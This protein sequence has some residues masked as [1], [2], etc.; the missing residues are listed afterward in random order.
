[1]NIELIKKYKTEFDHWL[2]GKNLLIRNNDDGIWMNMSE[3]HWDMDYKTVS[4]IIN[5]NFSELRK[6][7]CDGKIIQLYVRSKQHISDQSQDIYK[8]TDFKSLTP[9]SPFSGLLKNYRI[10]PEEPKFKVGDFVRVGCDGDSPK[11]IKIFNKESIDEPPYVYIMKDGT[12]WDKCIKCDPSYKEL[13]WFTTRAAMLDG[14]NYAVLGYFNTII[15]LDYTTTHGDTFRHC[16]PFLNS[17]P[18]WF[19]D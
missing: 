10:K 1:M 19:K 11:T 16:E 9:S 17:K 15:G 14:V 4:I 2:N 13:C 3:V 5:D 7:L 6:A 8:W 18:S 12:K